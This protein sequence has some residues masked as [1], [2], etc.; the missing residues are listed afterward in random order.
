MFHI[1]QLDFQV[2]EVNGEPQ[3]FDG[4]HDVVTLP[5]AASEVNPSVVKVIIPFTDPVILGEDHAA[6][7]EAIERVGPWAV[8]AS[9]SLETEPGVELHAT[10]LVPRGEGRKPGVLVVAVNGRWRKLTVK[11]AGLVRVPHRGTV[12]GLSAYALD[13]A[14]NKSRVLSARR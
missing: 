9:S 14:G 4:Y 5:A 1:H 8:D 2:T 12:R 11:S 10:L 3:P 7:G 6:I 13:L